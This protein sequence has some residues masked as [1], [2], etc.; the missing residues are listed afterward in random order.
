MQEPGYAAIDLDSRLAE[1]DKRLQAI[2]SELRPVDLQRRGESGSSGR[3]GPLASLLEQQR[4]ARPSAPQGQPL[5]EPPPP[6]PPAPAP[7][8]PPPPPEPSRLERHPPPEAPVER[9]PPP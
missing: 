3:E 4:R 8:P 7:E 6:E 2:Q 1:I 5:R 9:Y